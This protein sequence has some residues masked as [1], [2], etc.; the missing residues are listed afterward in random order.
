MINLDLSLAMVFSNFNGSKD[1]LILYN[2][3]CKGD[4]KP[5]KFRFSTFV[6]GLKGN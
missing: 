6:D 5:Y 3:Y 1:L 4:Y 2:S